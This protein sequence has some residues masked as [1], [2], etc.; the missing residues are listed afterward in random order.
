M[1]SITP[2]QLIE[3]FNALLAI[4]EKSKQSNPMPVNDLK[5][6]SDSLDQ[7]A[8]A[9]SNAQAA[10]GIVNL[11]NCDPFT[12]QKYVELDVIRDAIKIP[13]KDNGLSYVQRLITTPQNEQL[14]I[15]KLQHASGQ[16]TTSQTRIIQPAD[17]PQTWDSIIQ[18]TKRIH[19]MALCGITAKNDETDDGGAAAMQPLRN[20]EAKGTALEYNYAPKQSDAARISHDH[21]QELEL[22]LEGC[23]DIIRDIYKT[24]NIKTIADLPD[25]FYRK[26]RDRV[27]SLKRLRAST[28]EE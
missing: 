20:K 12:D 1:D 19:L 4:V 17:D 21:L 10:Y 5:Q 8:A 7:L 11:N 26:V 22:E 28:E 13:F 3:F 14:L 9:L 16:F 6:E 24:Y 27:I 15:T 25:R 18:H 23:P 2:L